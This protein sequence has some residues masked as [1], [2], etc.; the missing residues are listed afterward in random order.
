[1]TNMH[2]DDFHRRDSTYVDRPVRDNTMSWVLGALA[3]VAL[4]GVLFWSFG[5][6]TNTASTR[7]DTNTGAVTR[8]APAPTPAPAPTTGQ[9]TPSR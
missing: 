5:G 3:V 1:M 9:T 2:N 6:D 4:L 7:T 8:T